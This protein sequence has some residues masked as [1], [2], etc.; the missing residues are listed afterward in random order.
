MGALVPTWRCHSPAGRYRRRDSA[1]DLS[2]SEA[3]A[4][5][6]RQTH[7]LGQSSEIKPDKAS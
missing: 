3:E 4:A 5:R 1:I 2:T 7:L 6:G